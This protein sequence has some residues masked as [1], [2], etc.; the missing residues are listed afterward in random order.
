[1]ETIPRSTPVITDTTARCRCRAC[2]SPELSLAPYPRAD[3][4]SPVRGIALGALVSLP[5][6]AAALYVARVVAGLF[7][8]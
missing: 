3:H 7:G 2:V 4:G 6:W 5:I 8:F 1:M